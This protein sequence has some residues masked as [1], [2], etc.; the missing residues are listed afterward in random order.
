[1]DSKSSLAKESFQDRW[2]RSWN[3]FWFTPM[4]PTVLGAVRI[5]CGLITLYTVIAYSFALQQFMGPNAWY[6]LEDRLDEVHNRPVVVPSDLRGEAQFRGPDTP[7][8]EKYW[9]DYFAKWNDYPPPPF[10]T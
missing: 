9:R 3:A 10:P 4:D 7:E 1:M 8:E 5:C 6:G 2:A